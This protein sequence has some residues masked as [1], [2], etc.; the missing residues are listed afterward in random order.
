MR[1]GEDFGL[2]AFNEQEL[3][4]ILCNGLTTISTDFVQMGK[5]VVDL[6]KEKEIKTIRN[7]WRLILRKSL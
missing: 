2:V 7:P 3:N 6:V 1:V 5:T 4:E